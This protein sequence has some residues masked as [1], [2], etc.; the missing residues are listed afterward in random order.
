M[1]TIVLAAALA[2]V[3][4]GSASENPTEPPAVHHVG[5]IVVMH[6]FAVSLDQIS[7]CAVPDYFAP[8]P[9]NIKLGVEVDVYAVGTKPVHVNSFNGTL[10]DGGGAKYQSTFG[11]CTPELDTVVLQRDPAVSGYPVAS[12]WITFEIPAGASGL[13]FVYWPFDSTPKIDFKLDR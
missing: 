13:H 1:K 2:L 11:G 10:T 3:G 12:G 6:D 7:E 4:C 8:A 9:G 5:D